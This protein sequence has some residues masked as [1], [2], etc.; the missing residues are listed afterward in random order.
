MNLFQRTPEDEAAQPRPDAAYERGRR[1]GRDD[2]D[3]KG[4]IS[5]HD[6]ALRHAYERGRR[7]ERARHP[8]R[9]GSPL[10]TTLLLLAAFAGAFVVYLG[11]SRGSFTGG[12]Q[13]IDQNLSNAGRQA[14]QAGRDV[15]HKAGDTLENAGQKLKQQS[16]NG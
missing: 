12:G 11:V 5:E 1:D 15:V 13:A 9:R 10:L 6:S 14:E 2:V 16:A 8:R 4:L 7:D 3:E